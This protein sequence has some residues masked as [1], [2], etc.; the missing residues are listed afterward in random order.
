MLGTVGRCGPSSW[1]APGTRTSKVT[2][3]AYVLLY[4]CYSARLESVALRV[5]VA[6]TC[7]DRR[8][9]ALLFTVTSH[10][11]TL[12]PL[13]PV[14]CNILFRTAS[15]QRRCCIFHP[16]H[17]TSKSI[18]ESRRILFTSSCSSFTVGN[19]TS[20]PNSNNS[21]IKI[22]FE[23]SSYVRERPEPIDAVSL[24]FGSTR[25]A[26]EFAA[27]FV[28]A[29]RHVIQSPR[30]CSFIVSSTF[31]RIDYLYPRAHN[32]LLYSHITYLQSSHANP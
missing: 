19:S 27:V 12:K 9:G 22:L 31:V 30:Y 26:S 8:Q 1:R 23:K 3:L 11:W 16:V 6:E 2:Y 18:S 21:P 24:P 15:L 28:T 25:V 32:L 13:V 10:G 5:A 4:L 17:E 29:A 14:P 20:T 7:H